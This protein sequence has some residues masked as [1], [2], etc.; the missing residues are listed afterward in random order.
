M[1]ALERGPA[2]YAV[3]GAA[4]SGIVANTPE[5]VA[6]PKMMAGQ[7]QP[8]AQQQQQAHCEIQEEQQMQKQQQHQQQQQQQIANAISMTGP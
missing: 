1:R 3:A 6:T 8:Q 4:K 2:Y 7:Q 5:S